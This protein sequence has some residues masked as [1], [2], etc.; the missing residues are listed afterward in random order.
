[1]P[2]N[3]PAGIKPQPLAFNPD[4]ALAGGR[5]TGFRFDL[6]DSNDDLI[7]PLQ[8]VLPGGGL[9]FSA[10]TAIKGS[11]KMSVRD[12]GQAVDWLNV[13]VR[14]MA[15]ISALDGQPAHEHGLGVYICSA[16]VE[17][18]DETGCTREVEL[19]DK[20]AILDQDI[21]TDENGDPVMF[22]APVGANVVDT[23]VDLINGV[24]EATPAIEPDSPALQ[25][26]QVWDLG[27]PVLKIVNDLLATGGYASL[28]VDPMGN[29]RVSPYLP[30]AQRQ[31]VYAASA[32]FTVGNRSVLDP[33]W[34]KDRDIYSIPNRYVAV[35]QGD[36]DVE[37]PVAV[38]T[39]TDVNS[40]FS[41]QS[42][43]RWVTR[44]VT[45]VEA[46]GLV[47]LE[48]RAWMGLAQASSVSTGIALEHRFLPDLVVNSTIQ[49]THPDAE[50]DLLCYVTN[51]SIP[52]DAT[53]L[54]KSEIR[55]AVV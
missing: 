54:C 19:L 51:T 3:L 2:V 36:G 11:G 52:F 6:L 9:D 25:A 29:Y 47:E 42:R 17:E 41:F 30:P 4:D 33:N 15:L 43:G 1:M 45:G 55:E 26:S 10:Y 35:G 38:V 44:V 20:M 32:P 40:P 48:A 5:V 28:W 46:T 8:G 34:R 16:P 27:T 18:W 37:A 14:P 12:V 21:V 7:E 53:A 50:V 23:V 13:R 31:P 24:G 39:N 49:F 22:V